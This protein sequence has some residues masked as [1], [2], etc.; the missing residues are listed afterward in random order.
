M[1]ETCEEKVPVIQG[2]AAHRLLPVQP[3]GTHSF[4]KLLSVVTNMTAEGEETILFCRQ[5]LRLRVS[6]PPSEAC[7]PSLPPAAQAVLC[8]ED[9]VLYTVLPPLEH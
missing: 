1:E 5:K 9:P 2:P 6:L 8:R 7:G 4:L 3:K